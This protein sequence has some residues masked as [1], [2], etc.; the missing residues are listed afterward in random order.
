M[1]TSEQIA[2]ATNRHVRCPVCDKGPRRLLSYVRFVR[3]KTSLHSHRFHSLSCGH[4]YCQKCHDERQTDECATCHA[5]SSTGAFKAL[6]PRTLSMELRR[7]LREHPA[8]VHKKRK[9]AD[10]GSTSGDLALGGGS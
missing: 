8:I 7:T 9:I 3:L 10:R 2:D 6:M 4:S 5:P 1:L